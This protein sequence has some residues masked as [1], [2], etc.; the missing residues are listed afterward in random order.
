MGRWCAQT[1]E[2]LR[3]WDCTNNRTRWEGACWSF[4]VNQQATQGKR[5]KCAPSW[6][7]PPLPT[8]CHAVKN[9]S[10]VLT[11]SHRVSVMVTC[12]SCRNKEQMLETISQLS[13]KLKWHV[14]KHYEDKIFLGIELDTQ[15]HPI[16][17]AAKSLLQPCWIISSHT[18][19]FALDLAGVWQVQ[20]DPFVYHLVNACTACLPLESTGE[21]VALEILLVW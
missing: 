6:S 11:W 12:L 20:T 9:D 1:R 13:Q 15:N 21:A 2:A 19:C 18:S 8:S 17:Q 4:T 14:M 3:I 7:L 10:S 16:S 5:N